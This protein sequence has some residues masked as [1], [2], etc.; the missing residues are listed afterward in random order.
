LTVELLVCIN[1]NGSFCNTE[2][3]FNSLLKS[4]SEIRIDAN[5]IEFKNTNFYYKLSSGDINETQ[6]GSK[7]F[8]VK[9]KSERIDSVNTEVFTDLVRQIRVLIS[10]VTTLPA[11][12]VWDDL[13]HY[14]SVQ[15]YPL[16][17]EIENIL[18]KLITKFMLINVGASWPKSSL[19]DALK[20][21]HRDGA[22]TTSVK[23]K[24]N[25]PNILYDSDFIKLADFLFEEYRD[26]DV[27]E[28]IKKLSKI[29]SNKGASKS[30]LETLLKFIPKSN[31]DRYFV[32]HIKCKDEFLKKKWLRLYDLRCQIAHN[33]TFTKEDLAETK[34]IISE[35]KPHL[36]EANEKLEEILVPTDEKENIVDS[37][38]LNEINSF[39]S[40]ADSD[41][42]KFIRNMEVVTYL[43][44]RIARLTPSFE[45]ADNYYDSLKKLEVEGI[46]DNKT[47]SFCH[48]VM[49]VRND[50]DT[51]NKLDNFEIDYIN[52][53]F[54]RCKTELLKIRNSLAHSTD[55][56]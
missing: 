32:S 2:E 14:Y 12:T 33:N 50:N 19:P 40:G 7:Y 42:Q 49:T 39:I 17:H 9:L 44:F 34:R 23:E 26:F 38:E 20:S 35:V 25:N 56:E 13:S 16:I 47:S 29:D 53:E 27:N 55:S 8:N 36:E 24:T 54:D 52:K 10:K 11:Q 28:L 22:K 15:A 30:E 45:R 31:W 6:G 1:T 18:R 48:Y 5:K 41:I 43:I 3:S 51:L 4:N 46:L 21:S 37:I